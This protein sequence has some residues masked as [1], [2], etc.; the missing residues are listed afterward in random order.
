M[1]LYG[2]G[3]CF[4][5][6]NVYSLTVTDFSLIS[7]NKMILMC[8]A[9]ANSSTP[10]CLHQLERFPQLTPDTGNEAAVQED[11]ASALFFQ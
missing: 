3:V 2:Y 4:M 6:D 11:I 9:L 10:A 5:I 1:L 8:V 7:C